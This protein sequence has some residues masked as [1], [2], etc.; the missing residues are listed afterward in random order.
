MIVEAFGTQTAVIGTEHT[1][2]GGSFTGLKVY[3]LHVDTTNMA[4]GDALELRAYEKVLTGGTEKLAY[5]A[6]YQ[7]NQG[8]VVKISIPLPSAYSMKF[9]LLQTA[10]TG[11]AY[12]WRVDSL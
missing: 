11:R 7:H 2:N 10:G 5:Y 12:D 6:S 1:L 3:V 4:L 8:S 9:T